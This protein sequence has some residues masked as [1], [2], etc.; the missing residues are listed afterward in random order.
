MVDAIVSFVAQRLG[1]LLIEQ[2]FLR[3]VRDEVNSLKNKLEYML[4]FLKDADEKQDQDSRIRKW[5]SDIRDLATAEDI[6]DKF[7]I[8]VEEGGIPNKK[9]GFKACLRKY[10]C[11]Y[12]QASMYGIGKEI[13]ELKNRLDEICRNQE[14]FKIRNIEGA[15]EGSSS[16]NERFKQLRRTTPH[17]DDKHVVGFTED[18]ELLTSELLQ[19]TPHQSVIS[20]VG[21]GGL[22]KT[23][24]ARKLYNSSSVGDK[25]E[26]KGGVSLSKDYNIQDLLRRTIKS[27]KTP[28]KDELKMLEKMEKEDLECHLHELLKE[29][30]YLVVINDVW[31]RDAWASLRRAL[32]DNKKG[33][34]VIITTRK[35]VVAKSSG[36]RKYVHHLRLLE[37]E[38]SWELFCKN[39]FSDYDG[40]DNKTNRCPPSLEELARDMVRKCRGLPLAIV[41][42]GGLL[43]RKHPDE[44]PKLQGRFWRHELQVDEGGMP[45]LRGFYHNRINSIPQRLSRE[46]KTW[47]PPDCSESVMGKRRELNPCMVDLESIVGDSVEAV[48]LAIYSVAPVDADLD[49]HNSIAAWKDQRQSLLL[50]LFVSVLMLH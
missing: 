30:R 50:R 20:I 22:G 40:V 9:V 33:S 10:F 7:I 44:W 17:E 29:S 8:K 1:N 18:V 25:F 48:D 21:M 28:T 37:P 35:K 36:G 6:I 2:V 19:E 43:S 16:M 49:I 42:L 13:K 11:I 24:L 34:R 27:F 38:E 32:P 26:C 23:T 46:I 3:G 14:V 41:V 47:V 15:G 4:C 39:V 12:K 31:D 45:L 5:V